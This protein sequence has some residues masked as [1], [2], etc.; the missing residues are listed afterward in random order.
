[1]LRILPVAGTNN[2]SGIVVTWQ[3][4]SNRTYYLQR[5]S[6]LSAPFVTIQNDIPGQA[7]TTSYTDTTATDCGPYF[8]RAGVQ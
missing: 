4:V 2:S 7:G 6:D 3:S 1:V 5:S 8:Y